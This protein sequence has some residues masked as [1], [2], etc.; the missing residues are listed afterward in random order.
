VNQEALIQRASDLQKAVLIPICDTVLPNMSRTDS[1]LYLFA[2][3]IFDRFSAFSTGGI[4]FYAEFEKQAQRL[5]LF[6]GRSLPL[7]GGKLT[8]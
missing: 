3:E 8:V 7:F 5:A 1:P 6:V 4:D 2:C